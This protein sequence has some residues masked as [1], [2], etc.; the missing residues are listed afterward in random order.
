MAWLDRIGK[1]LSTLS[2]HL[3]AGG[4]LI[5]AILIPLLFVGI[6]AIVAQFSEA[7]FIDQIRSDSWLFSRLLIRDLT[8]EHAQTLLD[9]AVLDGHV[10]YAALEMPGG[11]ITAKGSLGTGHLLFRED[12]FFGQHGDGVYNVIIPV[13]TDDYPDA[14][15]KLSY[16]ESTTT[17]HLNAIYKNGL[18][19]VG[20]Y[21]FL[22]M[23]FG[24]YM[25]MRV[26]RP[27]RDLRDVARAVASGAADKALAVDTRISEVKSLAA[28][29]DS[30]RAKL[31]KHSEEIA[32]SETHL[33]AVMDNVMDAIVTTDANGIIQS[34]NPATGRIFGYGANELRGKSVGLLLAPDSAGAKAASDRVMGKAPEQ[35]GDMLGRR[36][37]ASEFPVEMTVSEMFLNEQRHRVV[38]FRDITERKHAEKELLDLQASLEQRVVRRTKE[39]AAANERL[40]YQALHDALT[41]LPN[42]V[43][44]KDRLQQAIQVAREQRHSLALLMLD[45]NRF[46]EVNDTLGHHM[47]DLLLQQVAKRKQQVLKEADTLARLGGDEFAV[48]I[49]HVNNVQEA[50]GIARRVVRIMDEPF[51]IEGHSFRIGTSAG[52]AIYPEH[53]TDVATLMRHADVALYVAKGGNSGYSV[54]DAVKDEH[55]VNRL[56]LM[57]DLRRGIDH[58]ELLLHY[59]PKISAT[60][61]RIS[62]VEALVR[63]KHPRRGLTMPDEFIYLAEHSGLIRPLTGWVLEA[64]IQQSRSFAVEGIDPPPVAVNLSMHN[65]HDAQLPEFIARVLSTWQMSPGQLMLEITESAIMADSV[66][67]LDVLTRLHYM[68]IRLAIDDFGTGYSSLAYLKQLPV[69]EIKIDKSFTIDLD[70]NPGDLVIVRST[71]DLAHNMGLKVTAEGVE[72]RKAWDILV[73][74]G[75][76]M[77]QGYYITPPIAAD[78][79]REWLVK[80]KAGGFRQFQAP[81]RT[82]GS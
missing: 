55:T 54:Y 57:N 21:V 77:L 28:D 71:I 59:Q 60:T 75:C 35:P 32:A 79:L 68:G 36:R 37:D 66:S 44:L 63:W 5:H 16:D 46:K 74:L 41:D 9:N 42:R 51:I 33:R 67:A 4:L 43:L 50:N 26:T 7:R 39:L 17:E 47:G 73:D 49:P 13:A 58:D 34:C 6:G 29:L 24:T 52:I 61:G 70:K 64:A 23:I 20:A 2:G 81:R 30:M 40:E 18:Y 22:S 38:V 45:L 1:Y 8:P 80:D 82:H 31:V 12:F 65:L 76:D 3:V 62:E 11:S 15:L 48:L 10:I 56:A 69:D 14:K 72:S 19:L 25:G 27:L 53:G 78:K